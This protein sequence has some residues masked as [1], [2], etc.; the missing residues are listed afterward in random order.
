MQKYGQPL[1]EIKNQIIMKITGNQDIIKALII[2]DEDFLNTTPTSEQNVI[3]NK[4]DLLVRQQIMLTR[5]I[6]AK[7]NKGMPYITSAYADFK[8]KSFN[9]QS[10]AV[11]FYII[12][13][14]AWEKTE[15]G[16]RYDYIGDK[17]DEIFGD[18]G[19]GKF[20]F[21]KRGDM[22]IDENFLGHYITF[23]I[24]DFGRW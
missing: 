7:T 8:K 20:E 4:P 15:Y 22:P 11:W 6:T 14:N 21:D 2:Q 1:T 18:S 9:Y 17:L 23:E 3:L 19:I 10:G 24:L 16:I 5:N 12:I 13:P